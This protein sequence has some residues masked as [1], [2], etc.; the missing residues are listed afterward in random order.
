[1]RAAQRR[2]RQRQQE[3]QQDKRAG[4]ARHRECLQTSLPP[5]RKA[6]RVRRSV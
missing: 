3:H 6:R 2:N 1:V 4:Q 5:P